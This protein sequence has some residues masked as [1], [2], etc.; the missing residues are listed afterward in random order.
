MFVPAALTVVLF[1]SSMVTAVVNYARG[2]ASTQLLP[3]FAAMGWMI[4]IAVPIAFLAGLL[5]E[6]LAFASVA[7][8]VSTLEH[9]AADTVETALAKTLR[10]PTLRVVFPTNDGWLD[11][12]GRPYEPP[13]DGSSTVTVLGDPPVAAFVHD[14]S[15]DQDRKLLDAAAAA[16]RL[17]LDNARLHAEVRAQLAEV[18]ASRQR[19]S[20][21]ADAERQRLE[22]DL[23]D[24]AQQRLLGIGLALGALRGRLGESTD[25]VLVDELERE[26]RS[27][28]RELRDLAQGIR[29]AILTD[30]GLVPA[31]SALARR[32]ATQVALDVQLRER[33][34]PIIEATAY[35]MVSEAL[36]NV[37]KHAAGAQTCVRAIHEAG[38]LVIEVSDSG[39]GGA[40]LKSG[41]GLSGLADRVDAVGGNFEVRS[42]LGRGTLLRAELPCV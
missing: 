17:S 28:I 9:V 38:R 41:T 33:F 11:V 10:D 22:R 34:S 42:P 20:A 29:P 31:L 14:P 23:H 18:R 37:V 7:D 24:G 40:S 6:R 5:N 27:A 26:L 21:A 35:Y 36:Q 19:I 32:A 15:L 13:D 30:Q 3:L 4:F 39:P 8:L 1:T 2:G 12:S 25:Q 16:T